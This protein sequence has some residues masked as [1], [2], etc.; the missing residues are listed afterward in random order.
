MHWRHKRALEQFGRSTNPLTFHRT[1]GTGE[2][3]WKTLI[4]NGWIEIVDGKPKWWQSSW[5]ISEAGR[6]ALATDG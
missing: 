1:P 3:T 4:G 2:A 5:R 6:A